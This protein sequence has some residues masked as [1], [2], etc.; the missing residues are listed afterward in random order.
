M[1]ANLGENIALRIADA[2]FRRALVVNDRCVGTHRF[3]RIEHRR[4]HIVLHNQFAAAGL[5]CRFALRHHGRNTLADK[6]DDAVQDSGVVRVGAFVFVPGAR[7]ELCRRVFPGQH[8]AHAGDR[9]GGVLAN[10]HDARMRMGRAQQLEMQKSGRRD[11]QR[12]ARGTVDDGASRGCRYAAAGDTRRLP[13][14]F[15]SRVRREWHFRSRH[16]RCIG[17]CSPSAPKEGL[18][19]AEL[20]EARRRHDQARRTEAAHWKP[21][22]CRK[23]CCIGC[24]SPVS[25]EAASMVGH[26]PVVGAIGGNQTRVHRLTAVEKHG[27]RRRNRRRR[28]VFFTPKHPSSRRNVRRHRP[29]CRGREVVALSV[30]QE[31]RHAGPALSPASSRRGSLRHTLQSHLPAPG[32]RLPWTSS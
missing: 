1:F 31:I 14:P 3:A 15:R 13:R 17:R 23:A 16:S 22:A 9:Q 11:V 26:R 6:A 30:H 20:L 18:A 29:M 8:G 2:G 21:W 10:R 4:K 5:G 19:A 24:S 12:V 28:S 25:R 27:C 32:G 7:I